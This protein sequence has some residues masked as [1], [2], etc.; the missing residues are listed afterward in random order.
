MSA[1]IINFGI[2]LFVLWRFAFKPL[3]KMMEKRSQEIEKSLAD[4]KKIEENLA[5]SRL[6]KD[7][8]LVKARKEA[9][10]IIMQAQEQGKKQGE[11][12]VASAKAEV[13]N[14]VAGAKEQIAEEKRKMFKEVKEEIVSL[15]IETTKKVLG[16]AVSKEVDEKIV[17]ES[18][19]DNDL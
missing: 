1:Q 5:Q 6:D 16:K 18:L 3:A 4:A 17:K 13:A 15:T 11:E 12:M 7:E 19:K 10:A 14:V 9:Q 8:V 2:V